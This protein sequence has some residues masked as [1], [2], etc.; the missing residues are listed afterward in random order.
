LNEASRGWVLQDTIPINILGG[1]ER[2]FRGYGVKANYQPGRWKVQVETTDG[3][4]IG[5]I[6]FRLEGVSTAPR[7]FVVDIE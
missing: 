7:S 2:G 5:R 6:Y 4:E 3:R 1:R